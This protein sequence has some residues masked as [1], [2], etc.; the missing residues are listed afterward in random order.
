MAANVGL[1]TMDAGVSAPVAAPA[2]GGGGSNTIWSASD[3]GETWLIGVTAS[4]VSEIALPPANL[5]ARP[6]THRCEGDC[7]RAWGPCLAEARQKGAKRGNGR[8]PEACTATRR[9]FS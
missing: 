2:P 3:A 1:T 7:D 8:N 9:A 4:G 5:A 6:A